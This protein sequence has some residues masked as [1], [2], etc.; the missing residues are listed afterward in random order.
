M[1]GGGDNKIEETEEQKALAEVSQK[2]WQ[3]YLE[4][5]RPLEN[6]YM[7]D[8]DRMN[9]SQQYNQVAGLAAVPVESEF[10]TAVA[11]TSRAM[12]GAGINPNSGAFKSQMSKLDRSKSSAKADSISQAQL[13][14]QNRY[15]GGI[16]NIVRMG[17][18]Q[19]T[20]SV[21]GLSDV[22]SMSG[23][24]AYNDARISISNSQDNAQL[25]G[26]VIGAGTR[27]GL[28]QTSDDGGI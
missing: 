28:Q 15:V 24:K 27:Y 14:Q 25:G 1:G 17:Q 19:S 16:Q 4:N 12:V 5:Y 7:D 18:G 9:T 8:V 6:A 3:D 20:Q 21:Q 22:A 2:Q 26:A 10:S 13:G 11:D 23:Q